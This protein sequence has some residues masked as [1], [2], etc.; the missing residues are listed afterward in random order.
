VHVTFVHKNFNVSHF[1]S[2]NF[3]T[4]SLHNISC[5]FTPHHYTSRHFTIYHVSSLH[6]TTLHFTS[7]YIMS[8]HSTSLHFTSLHNIS[9]QFTPCHYTSRHF[10][11]LLSVP[12]WIPLLVTTFLTLFLKMFSIQ[13]KDPSK[14]AGNWFQLSMV[15]FTKEY[16]PTSVLCFLFLIFWLWTSLLR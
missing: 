5:P 12:T 7:Q 3:K 16:L 8:V 15:L 13:G 6:I 14:P 9:C 4:K 11:H 2:L 10:T 1:T